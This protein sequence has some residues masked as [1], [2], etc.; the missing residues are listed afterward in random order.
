MFTTL[1][2]WLICQPIS[3]YKGIYRDAHNAHT[4][5][6]NQGSKICKLPAACECRRSTHRAP[7]HTQPFTKFLPDPVSSKAQHPLHWEKPQ[8][9]FRVPPLMWRRKWFL[10]NCSFLSSRTLRF[11]LCGSKSGQKGG[12]AGGGGGKPLLDT[13]WSFATSQCRY[14]LLRRHTNKLKWFSFILVLGANNANK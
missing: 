13:L 14:F 7:W 9:Q 5:T 3:I 2:F 1:H 10:R 12:I 6:H 11:F 8:V 4:H